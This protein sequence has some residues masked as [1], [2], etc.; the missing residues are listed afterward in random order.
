MGLDLLSSKI[1]V[2]DIDY[3]PFLEATKNDKCII[4]CFLKTHLYHNPYIFI[5]VVLNLYKSKGKMRRLNVNCEKC[6]FLHQ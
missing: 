1:S 5:A 4:L 2:T 3:R 6:V